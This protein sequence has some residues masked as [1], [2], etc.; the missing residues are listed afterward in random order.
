MIDSKVFFGLSIIGQISIPVNDLE[1]SISFYQDLLGMEFLFKAPPGLGFFNC[2]G[3]RILLDETGE[4][5]LGRHSSIIYFTV[6]D[7][8]I[9]Y[10][11]LS[12]RGVIFKQKPDLIAHMPD[13]DLWMSFF[14]DPD[15][16]LLALMSE[17][18][19]L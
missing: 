15:S 13:H 5:K 11:V 3:V 10:E 8:H 14:H 7:I 1:R 12:A 2:N 6:Q 9:S 16:N 18:R 19:N 17:V 4:M